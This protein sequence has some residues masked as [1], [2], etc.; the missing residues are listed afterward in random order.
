MTIRIN[1][2]FD[3]ADIEFTREMRRPEALTPEVKFY[4]LI[5]TFLMAAQV[6]TDDDIDGANLG[7]MIVAIIGGNNKKKQAAEDLVRAGVYLAHQAGLPQPK[8]D[9]VFY[10]KMS[11]LDPEKVKWGA[12][13]YEVIANNELI[14]QA[15]D[16]E[17]KAMVMA[18]R[19]DADFT[20]RYDSRVRHGSDPL[21][22]A[23]MNIAKT[24]APRAAFELEGVRQ[25]IEHV[26]SAY[27]SRDVAAPDLN[28]TFEM[29]FRDYLDDNEEKGLA[30]KAAE[31]AYLEELKK[32][33]LS[34]QVMQMY[35]DLGGLEYKVSL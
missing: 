27:W 23:E 21:C 12:R 5:G 24:I 6:A 8:G 26:W 4:A 25:A 35:R 30:L 20:G 14:K 31:D 11:E 29:H 1:Q 22:D 16:L 18:A 28:R 32:D 3:I 33:D 2:P 7:S 9:A 13:L 19:A 17:K 34:H 15:W 10:K